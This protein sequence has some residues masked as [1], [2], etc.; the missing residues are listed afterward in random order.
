VLIPWVACREYLVNRPG[1]SAVKVR[2]YSPQFEQ[3]WRVE[4]I[5]WFI[6]PPA[7]DGSRS[8]SELEVSHVV[9]AKQ[10]ITVVSPRGRELAYIAGLIGP[11]R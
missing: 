5:S 9:L 1:R 8:N 11:A 3:A 4:F 6:E 10:V 2:C 7:L